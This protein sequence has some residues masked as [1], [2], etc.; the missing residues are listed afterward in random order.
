MSK[1]DYYE[2]L[3]VSRD[4]SSAE[5][6]KAFK[7]RAMKFHPDRNPD[8]PEAAEKFKE[9]AEAYEVLSDPQKKQAYDQFGHSG[10][11]GMGGNSGPNFNDININDIF[12][13]IFGDVFGTRS[14]SRRQQRGSDLQY[15][16]DLSLRDAVLGT[17]EKIKI[18]SHTECSDCRGSGAEKGSS[19]VTCSNCRGSGQVRMQ[20]GFFSIQ[21]TCS[22]C[23]GTGQ[24][25]KNLCKTCKG[26]GAVKDNKTLSVNIPAGVDNGDKVRLTG[27]GEWMKNGQS[28][29]LYVAIRIIDDPIF[30]RDG[31]DL[32]IEAPIPF[33]ISVTGGSIKLPTLEDAISLKIPSNTQT[34]KIFRIK[35]KGASIVRD[36]KRGDILCRVVVETPSNLNNEQTKLLKQLS[37]SLSQSKN[38]PGTDTFLKAISKIQN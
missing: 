29:D 15:N 28:G 9:A 36:R 31:K 16:L 2:I 11:Q 14:R 3:G 1:R 8:N 6:K 20:Q 37:D 21:Q 35:G 30:E 19:P 17:Q 32:Y 23:K 38:Y 22:V 13:D 34:G 24:I 7:K 10:V 26:V 4:V 27:E 18:P 25:I 12:G 5:L 33:E